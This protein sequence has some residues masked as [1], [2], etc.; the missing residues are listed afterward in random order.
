MRVY[1]YLTMKEMESTKHLCQKM[2]PDASDRDGR[3]LIMSFNERWSLSY[4]NERNE[5]KTEGG[6]LFDWG[7]KNSPMKAVWIESRLK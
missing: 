1:I 6:I 4:Y 5:V 3:F 7:Q 2:E